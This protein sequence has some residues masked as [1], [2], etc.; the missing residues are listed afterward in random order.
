MR[1]VW[2][3]PMLQEAVDVRQAGVDAR[4]FPEAII[5]AALAIGRADAGMMP[6]EGSS[7]GGSEGVDESN[8][9]AVS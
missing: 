9:S 5:E 3:V 4:G 7:K 1:L 8:V 6:D 2:E